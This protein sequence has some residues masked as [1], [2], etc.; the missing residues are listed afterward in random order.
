[1]KQIDHNDDVAAESVSDVTDLGAASVETK[2]DFPIVNEADGF[3][4][5]GAL[6]E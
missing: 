6:T 3:S 1:M 5:L 2:G 4:P